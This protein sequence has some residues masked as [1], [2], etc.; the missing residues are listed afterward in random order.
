VNRFA[1]IAS[2]PIRAAV[3]ELTRTPARIPASIT[4]V[5]ACGTAAPASGA[6]KK[7]AL[8]SPAAVPQDLGAGRGT[9]K[10]GVL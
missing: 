7:G 4:Y 1:L 3:Y 2:Y 5:N 6:N 8:S 10:R 9:G